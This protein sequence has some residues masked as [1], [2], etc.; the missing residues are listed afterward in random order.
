MYMLKIAREDAK[1]ILLC[2]WR[3]HPTVTGGST[4]LNVSGDYV[5]VL[6]QQIEKESDCLFA[7]FQGEAGNQNPRTRMDSTFEYNPPSENKA[8]GKEMSDKINAAYASIE[9][10]NI[11]TGRIYTLHENK[12][13]NVNHAF[14]GYYTEAVAIVQAWTAN[15]WTSEITTML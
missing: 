8:Y 13:C 9:W 7:Y 4:K 1:D 5:A 14:D 3:A 6:R 11:P 2:N 12:E 10:E 15:G